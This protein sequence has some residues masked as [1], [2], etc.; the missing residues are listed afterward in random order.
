MPIQRVARKVCGRRFSTKNYKIALLPGDYCGIE[1]SREAMRVLQ[2]LSDMSGVKFSVTEYPFGG[3]GVDECGTPL[4]DSTLKGC[5]DSDAVLLGAIGGPKYDALEMKLRP[6]TGLLDLRKN[7]SLYC[8]VRP[9]VV[10]QKLA[11]RSPL[12]EELVSGAD[13]VVVRE[14]SAGIYPSANHFLNLEERTAEDVMKYD[15]PTIERVL[16]HAFEVAENRPRKK[17]TLVDKA[18]VLACSRLWRAVCDEVKTDYPNVTLDHCYIDAAVMEVCRRPT[19][20]DVMVTEN[21]MGDILSDL[22]AG[23][24]SIGLMPSYS[25]S[26]LQKPVHLFEPIHGSAPTI[27]EQ[28]KVNPL[29]MISCLS[30]MLRT[31]FQMHDIANVLDESVM[32]VLNDGI[33]TEDLCLPGETAVSTTEMTDAVLKALSCKAQKL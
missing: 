18:N 29:A 21:L 13:I 20:Y 31:S 14:L 3:A 19:N 27:F 22:L 33:F 4:P 15:G 7:L 24:V 11:S 1:V 16:R 17:V 2:R 6:E 8:N 28:N 30:Q 32:E 10:P 23:F 26:S 9:L 12:R 25:L 5:L